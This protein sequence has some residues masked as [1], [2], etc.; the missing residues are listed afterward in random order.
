MC[1]KHSLRLARWL[2][3]DVDKVEPLK[4]LPK[5]NIYYGVWSLI[6]SYSPKKQTMMQQINRIKQS[7]QKRRVGKQISMELFMG[8]SR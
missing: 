3:L 1:T 8:G 4:T 6:E 2:G 5:L 7:V